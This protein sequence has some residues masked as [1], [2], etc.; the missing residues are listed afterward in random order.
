MGSSGPQVPPVPGEDPTC[1]LDATIYDVR[2]PVDQI[3]R[4]DLE[5]LARASTTAAGF[6]KALAELGT[7]QPLYR[8]NQSIRLAGDNITI[9]TSMPYVTNSSMGRNGQAVNSV[10]YTSVGAQ[11]NLSGKT[12]VTG[13]IELDMSIQVSSLTDSTAE[14]ASGVKAPMFRN[15][16][17]SHKGMV[18]ASRPFVVVSVDAASRDADGKAVAYI[19]RI[20]LGAPQAGAEPAPG[21]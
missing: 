5:A 20:T 15:A 4:I 17:M 19:A 6:E 7:T 12:G 1:A 8:A 9:G 14:I 11:F 21:E 16:T 10:S 13:S 18:E 3:G 2:L